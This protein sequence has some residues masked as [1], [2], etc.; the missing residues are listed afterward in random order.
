MRDTDFESPSFGDAQDQA[1]LKH[2]DA[3]FGGSFEVMLEYYQK[4]GKGVAPDIA[5]ERI[6]WLAQEEKR[7]GGNLAGMFLSAADAE[8]I[9]KAKKAYQH[10]RDLY[11]MKSPKSPFPLLIANL[12]LSEEENPEEEIAAIV[13]Q[14]Q[15]IVPTLIGLVKSEDMYN[16]LYPGYGQAPY[17][18]ARCLG[19]IGDG[20]ALIALF[21]SIGKGDF[22]DD[23]IALGALK[24][25][26][27]PAKR[28]LLKVLHGKPINEDNERA[29]IALLAFKDPEVAKTCFELLKQLDLGKDAFLATYLILACEAL[30]G[31][32]QQ[33]EFEEFAQR[34]DL[35]RELKNDFQSILKLWQEP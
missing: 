9:K 5:L 8:E 11:Q 19:L 3:H 26:G 29:A 13:K 30:K 1:I 20:R 18:A 2:R 32:Q 25:I 4:G 10:L 23:D 33:K 21:E 17:L 14:R 35:P 31:T 7:L 12:I 16:P 24:S 28:F 27:E 15:A 22:F 6:E 34:S